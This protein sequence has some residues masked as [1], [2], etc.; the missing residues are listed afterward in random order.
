MVMA[1][2]RARARGL[3]KEKLCLGG[4]KGESMADGQ[5]KVVATRS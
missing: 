1:V 4:V 5:A 3:G 2:G